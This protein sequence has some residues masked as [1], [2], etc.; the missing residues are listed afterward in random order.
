MAGGV[1]GS[2]GV[3]AAIGAFVVPTWSDRIGRRAG[4]FTTMALGA[5][6][7]TAILVLNRL[8]AGSVLVGLLVL[9]VGG[10]AM[11][12]L[13][14]ALSLIPADTV[15]V[16]D[17]GRAMV[18]PALVAELAGGG[19]APAVLAILAAHFGPTVPIAGA[20]G[21]LTIGATASLVLAAMPSPSS[22]VGPGR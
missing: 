10:L 2:F 13:P 20:A 17:P 18:M 3:G 14:M 4:Q 15:A 1:L 16:G 6:S 5:V 21:L 22:A 9:G 12:G 8:D 11:G 19:I 7:G